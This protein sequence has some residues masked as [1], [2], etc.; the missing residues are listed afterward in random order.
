MHDAPLGKRPIDFYVKLI[1]VKLR[2]FQL[3]TYLVHMVVQCNGD[4]IVN[5]DRKSI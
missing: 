2:M 4:E 1:K 3:N 5:R